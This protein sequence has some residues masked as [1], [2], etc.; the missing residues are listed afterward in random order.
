MSDPKP[1]VLIVDDDAIVAESIAQ[2]LNEVGY[3]ASF[4]TSG[5]QALEAMADAE[6]CLTATVEH[7]KRA[8]PNPVAVLV[9][10]MSM[11]GMTGLELIRK[12]RERHPE[13]VPIVITGYGT[14]EA[15][16]SHWWMTSC[17]WRWRRRC[18]SRRSSPRTRFSVGSSTNATGWT[19]SSAPIRACGRYTM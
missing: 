18:G 5:E 16:A 8:K 17:A 10:D 6:R 3:E 15:A 9:V 14:I 19:T 11:P 7:V 4:R 13:V 12:T 1:C 2:Y